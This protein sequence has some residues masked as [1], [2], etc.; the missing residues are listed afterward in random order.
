MF[1]GCAELQDRMIEKLNSAGKQLQQ[2]YLA[3]Q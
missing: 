2:L 1:E 3:K